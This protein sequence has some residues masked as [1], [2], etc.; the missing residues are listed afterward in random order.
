MTEKDMSIKSVQRIKILTKEIEPSA[1]G[2]KAVF[3]RQKIW[4]WWNHDLLRM[5]KVGGIGAGG[6]GGNTYRQLLR[7]GLGEIVFADGDIVELSN[8]NRQPF[9]RENLYENK[10]IALAK[11]LEREAVGTSV[12]EGYSMNFEEV[13]EK[14]PHAYKNVDVALVLVDNDETR[15]HASAYFHKMKIPVIFAAVADSGNQGYVFLQ[16]PGN[17]CFNCVKPVEK[18]TEEKDDA[19][20]RYPC[21]QPSAI[22]IHQVIA[23]IVVYATLIKIMHKRAPWHWRDTFLR[24]EARAF[25]PPRRNDCKV[26]GSDSNSVRWKSEVQIS[27]GDKVVD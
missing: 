21:D 19:D 4:R 7:S 20:E 18:V 8:L 17:A 13:L 3:H 26:C 15:H 24:E 23:G 22:Y 5:S 27:R 6:L 12:I 9:Y 2:E 1:I 25:D 11:N 10:A 16:E 14:Y